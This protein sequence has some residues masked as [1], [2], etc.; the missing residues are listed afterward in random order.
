MM[1]WKYDDDDEADNGNN[2]DEDDYDNKNDEDDDN[3]VGNYDE[4][5]MKIWLWW[6]NQ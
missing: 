3:V 5:Y 1:I 4:D 2:D 6:W